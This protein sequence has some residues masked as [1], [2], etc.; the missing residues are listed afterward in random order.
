MD[1]N[2]SGIKRDYCIAG[3][4]ANWALKP[5]HFAASQLS[6]WLHGENLSHIHTHTFWSKTSVLAQTIL[7]VY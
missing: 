3:G 7:F 4:I 2:T 1:P 6:D 5:F